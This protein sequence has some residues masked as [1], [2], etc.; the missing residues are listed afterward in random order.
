MCVYLSDVT[1]V[2]GSPWDV[3]HT[4]STHSA[5]AP[6]QFASF[7][8]TV[9]LITNS[10]AD[11]AHIDAETTKNKADEKKSRIFQNAAQNCETLSPKNASLHTKHM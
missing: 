1:L 11:E 9:F 4:P 6:F 7:R 10:S 5:W 3:S 2:T 8:L